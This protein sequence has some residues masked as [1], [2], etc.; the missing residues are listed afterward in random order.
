MSKDERKTFGDMIDNLTARINAISPP[1]QDPEINR[2]KDELQRHQIA[3]Q[4]E[5]A[6]L[7]FMQVKI[8]EADKQVAF[9]QNELQ[10][11]YDQVTQL[12]NK[13]NKIKEL[14]KQFNELFTK[15]G[16]T[17]SKD[18]N[19]LVNDRIAIGNELLKYNKPVVLKQIEQL[20]DELYSV[21]NKL[22]VAMSDAKKNK[23]DFDSLS[24]T[25]NKRENEIQAIKK[26]LAD[27]GVK[28]GFDIRILDT[29]DD[30][31]KSE[32]IILLFLLIVLLVV[33]ISRQMRR[34]D[35]PQKTEPTKPNGS[36]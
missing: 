14:A 20:N 7:E 26:Q 2:L 17:K 13:L 16:K 30:P 12:N 23:S 8:T 4:S 27:R 15:I 34:E 18:R 28:E 19:K 6:T 3:V 5:K 36:T 22:K 31:D 11:V 21:S 1:K 9:Y 35:E 10:K 24:A 32:R 33:V 25:I 29:K